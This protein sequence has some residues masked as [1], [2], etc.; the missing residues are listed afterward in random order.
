M[1]YLPTKGVLGSRQV[2][3]SEYLARFNLEWEYIPG[4][5][6]IA[7]ALSRMPCLHLY[8]TTRSHTQ[9]VTD[10]VVEPTG[11]ASTDLPIKRKPLA[12]AE[13]KS[14]DEGPVGASKIN[15]LGEKD[16]T[17]VLEE[18]AVPEGTVQQG[19][20]PSATSEPECEPLDDRQKA[21]EANFI[22]RVKQ[23]NINDVD[24]TKRKIYKR[25]TQKDGL[26]WKPTQGEHMALYIPEDADSALRKECME[27]VHIHPFSGH[28]GRDRTIELLKRDFWWSG[29]QADVAQYVQDCEM[30]SRNKAPNTKKAGLLSPLPIPGRPW[31]SIGMDFITHLPRTKAGY[32][33]LYVVVD[34]L[35][36]LVHMTPTTDTATAADTAQ[37]FL[38]M[39]F[40][41]HGLPSSIVSD[42]D[43][44]FTSSFWT[45]FCQ[46]VGIKLKMSTA[47]HPETDGQTERMNRVIVDM[48]RHYI[49][50]THDD[51]DEHLTA[52]EFA[53][54]NAYQQSIGTT[55]FRLT[56]GQNPLT[57]VSLRIPKVENPIA[58][59]VNETLQERLQKAKLCLEA[60]QQRQKAYADQ[61]RRP[62]EYK[63]GDEVLLSTE[64]IKRAGIGTP[65]F[66]PLWIGPF[67]V[68]KRVEPTAYELELAPGMKMHDVFHVSLLK[69][70]N[71]EKHGVIPIPPTLTLGEQE[72]FEVQKILDHRERHI[73][74][75]GRGR[76]KCKREYLV[77]WRGQDYSNSTWEPEKNL[78]NA[79]KKVDE[80]W[81][82][83]LQA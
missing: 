16:V 51:W 61:D 82:T 11:E 28:V 53:I 2:R 32:T 64:N 57:P 22:A 37:L 62:M 41:H 59:R 36:K 21:N 52:I 80:Y 13:K 58:L 56:Y 50:P 6:N 20:E 75:A 4:Q 45:S 71:A 30:C 55:P 15:P 81:E 70:W 1:T 74:H 65:K 44:K 68:L 72:E 69:P 60:A 27:W 46:Q 47:Y 38:D 39:V 25:L 63:E 73:S 19:R 40:K 18:T 78:Q 17:G 35:T 7:D 54:N 8:V 14:P 66:M 33:A 24:L 12:E 76:P 42:R 77:S 29:L 3:W 31:E 67:K 26:W 79:R 49:S 10:V 5:K 83:R 48:L 43:V 23:A 9:R 34:R